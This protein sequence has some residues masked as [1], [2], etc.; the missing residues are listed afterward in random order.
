MFTATS[1]MRGSAAERVEP[2]LKPN[3]PNARTS[4]PT[5]ESG[6]LWP[7]I[8]PMVPSARN[9]PRRGPSTRVPASAVMP[10]VMWTTLEPAKSTWPWPSPVFAPSAASQPW[11]HTQWP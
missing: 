10:P 7:G 1:A 3:Q 9:L 4:V 8:A 2:A 5:T 6:R 11:P